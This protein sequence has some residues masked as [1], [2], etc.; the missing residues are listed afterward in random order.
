MIEGA[1]LTLTCE[2]S[3]SPSNADV[4]ITWNF[5]G[6]VDIC[7]GRAECVGNTAI[8]RDFMRADEGIYTCEAS[9]ASQIASDVTRITFTCKLPVILMVNNIIFTP[10]DSTTK[11]YC[12][13]SS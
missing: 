7:L 5:L 8:I 10:F 13:W 12:G 11:G 4:E 2:I 3:V 9:A 6:F 1:N